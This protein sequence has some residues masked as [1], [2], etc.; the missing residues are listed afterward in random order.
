M[1]KILFSAAILL[2]FCPLMNAQLR[3]ALAGGGHTST[4]IE[5]NTLPNWSELE[6][7]FSGRTGAHFGFL[8]DLQLGYQ[9]K[10]YAQPGVMFY[11]KGRKFFQ[12][13][14]TAVYDY[15]SIDK[16]QFINYVDIP[17]NIVYKVPIGTKSKFFIGGGPYLSFFYNGKEKTETY[18]KT[19]KYETE[20]NADLPV[21]NAP[22][23]YK[24][25]DLGVNGTAGVE[26]GG[27]FIAGNFSRSITD[28]YNATYD[29]SFKNQVIGA[30]LGIFIGK[31]IPVEEK[32]KDTD[33]DGINDNE[34]QCETEPGPLVTKGCPDT[35]GDGIADRLDKCP[36]EKGTAEAFGCPVKEVD[37]DSD[38]IFD[39]KDK[40]KDVPGV[41]KYDGC[42][43]P[44]TDKDAINDDDD[45][46]PTVPGLARYNGCPIPDT[47]GDG[48]NN[49]DDKCINEPGLKENNGCPEI[50]KEIV[51]KVEYAARKIQFEF[52]KAELLPE[53]EKVLDEL[54]EI[55]L[56]ETALKVD[57][58]GHTSNDGSLNANMRLSND[59]AITVK[60]YFITKGVDAGRLT[61]QGFGPS[62]PL[63]QGKTREEKALNRRVELKLRNN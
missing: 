56:K 5:K 4:I 21:G 3:I 49:E 11:N 2:G 29:G 20:E 9:S 46:C 15:F 59:R 36:T 22:G 6:S 10:F 48:V 57:I 52:G 42:P 19:G 31:P 54:A 1:K 8:A 45:K 40:C 58:E 16:N 61:A 7:G 32:Q 60:N 12:N 24:T 30:T 62:K 47:D 35:D 28:M 44:D 41:Q 50:K 33:K 13:Y 55:L 53:S 25:F 38:G 63:N 39:S 51:Q 23:K 34:D 26:F 17:L 43:V 37:S 27:F 14:D 18:L